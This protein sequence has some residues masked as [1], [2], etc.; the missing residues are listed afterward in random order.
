MKYEVESTERG[1]QGG[2]PSVSYT[3]VFLS[4]RH[5]LGNQPFPRALIS[6]YQ[7]QLWPKLF[8]PELHIYIQ[9]LLN[10][11][12]GILCFHIQNC[13]VVL[14][15]ATC[16]CP[17]FPC[18]YNGTPTRS[19]QNLWESPCLSPV[20]TRS[21]QVLWAYLQKHIWVWTILSNFG[22]SQ[23]I[24]LSR[25]FRCCKKPPWP[26]S[27]TS[28]LLSF[29]FTHFALVSLALSGLKFPSLMCPRAFVFALP[30]HGMLSL[31]I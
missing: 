17:C 18:P 1:G 3:V 2:I 31:Q 24:V 27:Q 11:S 10:I 5:T 7:L 15:P 20:F 12:T 30:L 26:V 21:H 9:L 13:T 8:Y 23:N 22:P 16:F 25:A 4:I 14:S 28:S 19:R 6:L 29:L